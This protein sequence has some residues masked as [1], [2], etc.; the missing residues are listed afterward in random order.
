[1]QLFITMIPTRPSLN[2]EKIVRKL[3]FLQ[4]SVDK[5][6]IICQGLQEK[7]APTIVSRLLISPANTLE[8]LAAVLNTPQIVSYPCN[9][10]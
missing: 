2:E 9:Y 4:K 8:E 3:E 1:M 7:V 6:T 5:L 10:N